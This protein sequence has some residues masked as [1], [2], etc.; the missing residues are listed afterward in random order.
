[1]WSVM[2]T[3]KS[4]SNGLEFDDDSIYA[5]SS[6]ELTTKYYESTRQKILYQDSQ[7]MEVTASVVNAA[8][9]S[10]GHV[11]LG[12]SGSSFGNQLS[13][14]LMEYRLWSEPL[15]QSIFDNHVRAPKSYNGNSYSSSYHD[16]LV[17]YTLDNNFDLSSTTYVN[18]VS[19]G[20]NYND[21]TGSSNG[22]TTNTFRSLVAALTFFYA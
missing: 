9:T 1:M 10:S 21:I 13:G 19:N 5:S 18:N 3:R 8:F 22:F 14:S 2:L 20:S 7:S 6:F 11:Y 17:R 16:L 15:S 12:G 4:A